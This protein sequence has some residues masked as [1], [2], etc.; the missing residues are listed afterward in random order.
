[1]PSRGRWLRPRHAGLHALTQTDPPPPPEADSPHLPPGEK[2]SR[3]IPDHP[4]L[5]ARRASELA[6]GLIARRAGASCEKEPPRLSAWSLGRH[7]HPPR[8]KQWQRRWQGPYDQSCS[9]SGIRRRPHGTWR[10]T[11]YSSMRGR[12]CSGTLWPARSQTLG[13]RLKS[14]DSSPSATR[15]RVR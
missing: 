7:G 13:T 15:S 4:I 3:G 14:I 2:A 5:F 12:R 9:S 10:S 1:M 8:R 11:A 6:A